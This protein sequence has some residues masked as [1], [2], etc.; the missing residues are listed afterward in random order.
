MNSRRGSKKYYQDDLLDVDSPRSPCRYDYGDSPDILT[1]DELLSLQGVMEERNQDV[2]QRILALSERVAEVET[3]INDL[4]T[5]QRNLK[6]EIL[7]LQDE[8]LHLQLALNRERRKVRRAWTQLEHV[9][10]PSRQKQQSFLSFVLPWNLNST[11]ENDLFDF[12][13]LE[14][15]GDSCSASYTHW[16]PADMDTAYG[17]SPQKAE[18][19]D[20][21]VWA[22]PSPSLPPPPPSPRGFS[23]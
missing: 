13:D 22:P 5:Q 8:N 20:T 14:G 1:H 21:I 15:Y 11:N 6:N 18:L 4:V 7:T 2:G 12:A 3:Y 23:H 16:S 17:P 9:S 19:P 10:L